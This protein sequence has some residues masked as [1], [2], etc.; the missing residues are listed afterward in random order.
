MTAQGLGE[1]LALA[2]GGG[3]KARP[4]LTAADTVSRWILRLYLKDKSALGSIEA[5]EDWIRGGA[6]GSVSISRLRPA[7]KVE[8]CHAV[9]VGVPA[10]DGKS[11]AI[12]YSP[13]GAEP[14]AVEAAR[15][16][17][18]EAGFLAMLR[19]LEH[20]GA[21]G[22]GTRGVAD[23]PRTERASPV[24]QLRGHARRQLDLLGD[25]ALCYQ[26]QAHDDGAGPRAR[27]QGK[28]GGEQR[29]PNCAVVENGGSY[30]ST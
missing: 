1:A 16:A 27:A 19:P 6:A 2:W 14:E 7:G 13:Q 8:L 15:R 9:I 11:E 21:M 5:V 29:R 17:S 23:G 30:I 4:G 10:G 24:R 20:A 28:K 3:G 22:V 12:L 25:P 18:P 26:G